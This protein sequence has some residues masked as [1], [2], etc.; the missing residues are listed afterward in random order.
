MTT[1]SVSE[2]RRNLQAF[3]ARV[4]ASILEIATLIRLGR[5]ALTTSL[6]QWLGDL[7]ALPEIVI[8]TAQISGA[9]LVTADAAI[10]SLRIV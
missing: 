1:T 4:A 8:A 2:L 6:E 3:L 9:R 7:R 5:L 10:R